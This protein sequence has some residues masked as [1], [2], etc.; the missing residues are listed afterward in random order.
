MFSLIICTWLSLSGLVCSCQNPTTCPS[1]CTTIPNLSQFLPMEIA[2]GPFPL[3]PT[4]EQH[5]KNQNAL[6]DANCLAASLLPDSPARLLRENDI[7]GMVLD[8]PFHEANAREVFPVT[9]RLLEESFVHPA[10]IPVYFVRNHPVIPNSF[11][12]GGRRADDPPLGLGPEI[13]G[14][15]NILVLRD[16]PQ[17]PGRVN[18]LLP[19]GRG[20]F[21]HRRIIRPARG[22]TF[23]IN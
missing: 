2:W 20:V 8:G 12:P 5:L 10:E 3:L 16:H 1:S 6:A 7:V 14:R 4:N 9:H 17:L 11:L 15:R 13:E 23:P 21:R 18:A 19:F 22:K